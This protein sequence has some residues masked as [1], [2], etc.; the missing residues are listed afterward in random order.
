MNPKTSSPLI[1]WLAA[2]LWMAA[3]FVLS[4]VPG[5]EVQRGAA[6]IEDASPVQALAR[7]ATHPVTFHI[8]V[9]AVLGAL[10]FAA[11]RLQKVPRSRAALLALAI[12]AVYGGTDE[13]HQAF[14]P[15]RSSSAAD[16]GFDAL[17]AVAGVLAAWVVARTAHRIAR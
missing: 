10:A 3:I 15:G 4:S 9:Y 8:A 11:L 16:V 2:V 14:V 7:V 5:E 6:R 17:G 12:A 1:T 13:L